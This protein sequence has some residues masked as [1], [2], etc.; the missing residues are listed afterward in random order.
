MC[1]F[2]PNDVLVIY[3]CITN[4]PKTEQLKTTNIY[5][6]TIFVG[7]KD[8]HRQ[9][10]TVL[11]LRVSHKAAVKVLATVAIISKVNWVQI[12]FQAHLGG[13]WQTLED[14]I[15]SSL[16]WFLVGFRSSL[17]VSQRISSLP[18]GL[19]TELLKTRQIV[20]SPSPQVRAVRKS[21]ARQK[22]VLFVT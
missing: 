22:S 19:S 20:S 14:P 2:L 9:L 12:P 3:C 11:W 15:P 16:I 5:Y 1:F 10:S 13:S 8:R 21:R 4:H 17:A 6:L 18:H 7:Q